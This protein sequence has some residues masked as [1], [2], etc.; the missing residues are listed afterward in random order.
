MKKQ[1]LVG[2]LFLS[3]FLSKFVDSQSS[4]ITYI[5]I[6]TCDLIDLI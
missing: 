3:L 4:E 6:Y 1:L 2:L 5:D